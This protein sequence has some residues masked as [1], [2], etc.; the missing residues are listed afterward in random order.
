MKIIIIKKYSSKPR[1]QFQKVVESVKV[2]LWPWSADSDHIFISVSSLLLL[3]LLH[4]LRSV[5]LWST[6]T[7]I[8]LLSNE[9]SRNQDIYRFLKL[10]RATLMSH[11][12]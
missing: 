7:V 9:T 12:S 5:S 4:V 3:L 2:G 8:C 11:Q 10:Q 6:V 1:F